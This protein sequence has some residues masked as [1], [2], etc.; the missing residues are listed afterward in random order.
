[1]HRVVLQAGEVQELAGRLAG[2]RLASL[3][4]GLLLLLLQGGR[5]LGGLAGHLSAAAGLTAAVL[6]QA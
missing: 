4:L 1:M 2:Q 6:L 3:I 5:S